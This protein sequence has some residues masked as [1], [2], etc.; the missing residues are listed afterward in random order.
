MTLWMFAK[1]SL[2]LSAILVVA[3]L[4]GQQPTNTNAGK[5]YAGPQTVNPQTVNPQTVNPQRPAAT[6]GS[7]QFQPTQQDQPTQAGSL[8]SPAD[9]T[10]SPNG[11]GGSAPPTPAIPAGPPFPALTVQQRERLG[12]LLNHWEQHSSAVKT[13]KC[14][15]TRYE[16]NPTFGPPQD[17]YIIDEGT[18]R[19]AAPD[20]GEFKVEW[21]GKWVAPKAPGEKPQYPKERV[22][23]LEHWIC[24]GKSVYELDGAQK[25]LVQRILPPEMQGMQIADGPLPFMFGASREKIETRYWVREIEP[26]PNRKGEI[27]LEVYPKGREDA[28]SF[29][30]LIV[31]LAQERFLPVGLCVFPPAF[32]AK[33]NPAKTTYMLSEIHVNK[34]E[35]RGLNFVKLFITPNVPK[36]WKKIVE[37]FPTEDAEA[38]RSASRPK[39]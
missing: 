19:Y 11:Q 13:Y 10:F 7:P 9:G 28:A 27:W 16:Y 20:K 4:H 35:D 5:P 26:A 15:F 37:N 17:P 36:D 30:K 3:P 8:A 24:D 22:E 18:I 29:Q 39:P 34:A 31:I 12:V 33:T 1:R 23:F 14:R 38:P 25:R 21:R 32:D 2:V 6:L